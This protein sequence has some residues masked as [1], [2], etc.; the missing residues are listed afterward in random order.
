M[1]R[2]WI[3]HYSGED[4]THWDVRSL[5]E[6]RLERRT[7]WQ[8]DQYTPVNEE[9]VLREPHCLLWPHRRASLGDPTEA[10]FESP[11]EGC[12]RSGGARQSTTD[13]NAVCGVG[14]PEVISC[15]VRP[16]TEVQL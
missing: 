13:V 4:P 5:L 7:H 8:V 9:A 12:G 10:C 11:G 15:G 16:M 1:A 2:G 6:N 3:G 14:R